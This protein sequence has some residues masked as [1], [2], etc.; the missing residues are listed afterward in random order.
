MID[1]IKIDD[2]SHVERWQPSGPSVLAYDEQ[3]S[4]LELDDA[5]IQ[6]LNDQLQLIPLQ[7]ID[8]GKKKYADVLKRFMNPSKNDRANETYK[9]FFR[10]VKSCGS[11]LDVG[12]NHGM[13][14]CLHYLLHNGWVPSTRSAWDLNP[15]YLAFLRGFGFDSFCVN[16]EK[17]G[18]VDL[19]E[20]KKYDIVSCC[21]VLEHLRSM[22][23]VISLINASF[24][25]V[26]PGGSLLFTYP[27]N[28]R[29][30]GDGDPLGHHLEIDPGVIKKMLD[31][32]PFKKKEHSSIQLKSKI[33]FHCL[34]ERVS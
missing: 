23:S 7:M 19:S 10:H 14:G 30:I 34:Y 32:L 18:S 27:V 17:L 15:S 26:A 16:F 4:L 24:D 1:F 31:S 6:S 13:F 8:E 29:N 22:S 25:R 20:Q 9:R 21:E 3:G 2:L 33:Q 11:F 12:S 28:L 5:E